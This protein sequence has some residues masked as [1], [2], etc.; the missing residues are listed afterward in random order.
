MTETGR[1]AP[2]SGP[3][4]GA[5]RRLD[6]R[7]LLVHPLEAFVRFL[8]AI[9]AIVIARAGS[10]G[11]DRWEL[12]TLPVVIGY[13]VL[14]WATTRYRITDGQIEL[15]RG[16]LTRRTTTARLDKVRTV[17]LTARPHH[18]VLRLAK[19]EIS[20]GGATRERLVLDSL[21]LATGQRLRTELLHRV[22]PA[23][24]DLPPPTGPAVEPG[25]D[26][27][28][29]DWTEDGEVELLRL[30]PA[31]IRYA[32]LTLTGLAAAGAVVGFAVQG[33]QQ[34][35]RD[36][37]L[38]DSGVGWVRR[39]PW[40]VDVALVVI[41]VG[42]LAVVAYVLSFWGFRLTRSR[43]DTLHTRR[44]LLTTRETTIDRARVRGIELGEPLGLRLGGASRLRA[45]STGLGGERGA[46]A[47][48]LSPPAPSVVVTALATE[49]IDDAAAVTG[50][51]VDHGPVARRRRYTRSLGPTLAVL[52]ML[53]LARRVWDWDGSLFLSAPVVVAVAWGLARDRAGALGHALTPRHLVTRQGSFDRR[54]VALDR[55]GIVGWTVRQS[56]FQRR[57]GVVTL[58]ATTAA[59]A[60]HYDVVDLTPDRAHAVMAAVDPLLVAQFAGVVTPAGSA[61]PTG[62]GSGRP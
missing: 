24:V 15:S 32:P 37:A 44:G 54:R 31:W 19:V 10:G 6:A 56:F 1:R 47:D 35:G 11:P 53:L 33:L 40:A 22:P 8:P 2:G 18:R 41:V 20:T 52:G 3:E 5:W 49:V 21:G 14:R 28:D 26:P 36:N 42:L 60:Q 51:L 43:T 9:L 4:P 23:V 30:S 46:G 39:L 17:D 58:I 29:T 45:V 38:V 34:Y 55:S 16:L 13:G 50:P 48:W 61:R 12:L 62:A 59:G 57:A 25:S 27:A 7:M